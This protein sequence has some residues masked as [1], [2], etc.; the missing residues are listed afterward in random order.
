M[1]KTNFTHREI[2]DF[3]RE[4]ALMLHSGI[5][6][7][8]ALNLLE[9]EE[10]DAHWREVL[11]EMA[12]LTGDGIALSEAVKQTGGFPTYMTGLIDVGEETGRLEEAFTS[13][14]DYYDERE[15]MNQR[16]RSALL[17]PCILMLLMIAVIVVLLTKVLPILRSV[18]ASLGSEM[19]GIAGVLLQLG[20][21]LNKLMPLLLTVLAVVLAAIVAFAVSSSV[22][23]KVLGFWRAKAGDR[24]VMRAMNDACLARAI[25]MGLSSGLTMEASLELA[26]QVL[27]DIPSAQKRC[28]SCKQSIEEGVPLAKALA[29]AEMFPHSVRQLLSLSMRSGNADSTMRDLAERLSDEADSTLSKKV[30]RIEPT[31]V[32]VCS[33][34]VGA[35]L[36]SVLL[37]LIDIMEMIG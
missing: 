27:S 13:L 18:Y 33:V 14:A 11:S 32:L 10:N 19:T 36:L 29:E 24:G 23:E 21:V 1:R 2:A 31:L 4:M 22:R 15:R 30:A 16:T 37:P 26:S 35:V 25:S 3:C 7:T 6:V 17:Y 5:G 20:Y 8:E 9:E 28:L 34:L 12:E